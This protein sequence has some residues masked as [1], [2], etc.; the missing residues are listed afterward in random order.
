MIDIRP[1]LREQAS[2]I[3]ELIMMAMN[4]DCCL[5]FCGEGHGLHDFH[6]MMKSLV[7]RTDSQYSYQNTLA[8]MDGERLA[9]ILTCYDGGRLHELRRAF[10][11]SARV[12]LGKDHSAMDDETGPGEL[13]LDS[14]AVY[15]AYRRQGIAA[16]LLQAG[17][18]RAVAMGIG[19]AGLLVDQG[20]PDAE[21]LYR[22]V[23]FR[24]QNDT[25]WGGHPM[26]HLVKAEP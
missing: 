25:S 5:Y 15:P 26:R 13:Y 19:R 17:Y 10:I 20:N 11:E 23:G 7:E 4:H 8:A 22:R 3:A 6:R 2:Q 18:D 12:E 16:R 24:W 14:M 9:G 1:A 21:R